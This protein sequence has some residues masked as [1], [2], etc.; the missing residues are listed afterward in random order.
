MDRLYEDSLVNSVDIDESE[1][2]YPL[3]DVNY[4]EEND[5]EIEP[6]LMQV[7]EDDGYVSGNDP[8]DDVPGPAVN[9]SCNSCPRFFKTKRGLG[10]HN[11]AH[12]RKA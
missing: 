12:K 11:A 1:E 10:I 6:M 9:Y 3:I 7:E 5:E 8:V 4:G 2:E